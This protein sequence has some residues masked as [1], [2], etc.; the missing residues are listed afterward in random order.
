M[1]IWTLS[2]LLT[3]ACSAEPI[4]FPFH[5]NLPGSS[6]SLDVYLTR[7]VPA[8]PRPAW[9]L[10]TTGL[11]PRDLMLTV[12]LRKGE[13]EQAIPNDA[14]KMLRSFVSNPKALPAVGEVGDF[15][16]RKVMGT[17]MVGALVTESEGL[18]GVP[19][20][21]ECLTLVPLFQTE[22]EVADLAGPSRVIG[23]LANQVRYYPCPVWCDRTRSSVFSPADLSRMKEDPILRSH[24]YQTDASFVRAAGV[25]TL[26]LTPARADR[27]LPTLQAHAGRPHR[28]ALAVDPS[29]NAFL[30]WT[31]DEQ[32]AAVSPNGSDGSRVSVQSLCLVPGQKKSEA[33]FLNDGCVVFLTDA[34]YQKLIQA[35]K[36]RLPLSLA[37]KG[38]EMTQLK[39]AWRQTMYFDPVSRRVAVAPGGWQSYRSGPKKVSG[40]PTNLEQVILLTPEPEIARLTNADA[41]SGF[42]KKIEPVV[43]RELARAGA[44]KSRQVVVQCTLDRKGVAYRVVP[45]NPEL[46]ALLGKVP[47][48]TVPGTLTFQLVFQVKAQPGK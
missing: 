31:K 17:D 10:K 24:L 1:R 9:C 16:G 41:L 8:A 38:D 21:R 7:V 33:R 19:R 37:V 2:L 27:I 44:R 26:T 14:I 4:K 47:P 25:G 13:S 23:G 39:L 15:G 3:L 30:V 34:D 40:G 11:K 28:L 22:L 32:L 48:L 42:I 45:E 43:N 35:L 36:K 6:V 12:L 5:Q 18:P 46:Q 20:S 29:A